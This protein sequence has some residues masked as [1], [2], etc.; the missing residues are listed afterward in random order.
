MKLFHSNNNRFLINYDKVENKRDFVKKILE[1]QNIRNLK[2]DGI[3]FVDKVNGN[4]VFFD[5]FN[6]DGSRAEVSGNGLA[7]LSLFLSNFYNFDKFIFV[8]SQFPDNRFY[9][10][11]LNDQILI[12]FE[13]SNVEIKEIFLD[14]G[15]KAYFLKIPNPHLVVPM[16]EKNYDLV[17]DLYEKFERQINVHLFNYKDMFMYTYERGVGFTQSCG[18]GTIACAYIYRK[19]FYKNNLDKITISS[20]GGSIEILVDNHI[21]WIATKPKEIIIYEGLYK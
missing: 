1:D 5:L 3:I 8:N 13:L 10:R 11:L 7:C 20:T 9:S 4:L 6:V 14:N 15:I 21:F 2:L 18:S 19:F 17:K 12:G 16:I